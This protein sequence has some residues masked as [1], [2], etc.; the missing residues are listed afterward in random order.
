MNTYTIRIGKRIDRRP[1]NLIGLLHWSLSIKPTRFERD[2]LRKDGKVIFLISSDPVQQTLTFDLRSWN[3]TR[4]V[5]SP[6]TIAYTDKKKIGLKM[7]EKFW[8]RPFTSY[9]TW[10]PWPMTFDPHIVITSFFCQPLSTYQIWERSDKKWQS[11][12]M[13]K[14]MREK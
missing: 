12:P 7:T 2:W 14:L 10:W 3:F 11:Y 4:F 9:T 13:T 5:Y 8:P 6:K 1:W